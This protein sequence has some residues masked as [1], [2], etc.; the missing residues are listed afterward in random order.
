MITVKRFTAP[1]C[2]P[3]RMLAP[4]F[5]QM[6]QDMPDITF[7]TIDVDEYPEQAS[8]NDVRSVPTVMIYNSD[9]GKTISLV[10]ANSKTS[11]LSAIDATKVSV[12]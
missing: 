11:Y 2:A 12:Q 9:T 4:M 7:E 6:E 3:C 10:G 1:W 5:K 8:E